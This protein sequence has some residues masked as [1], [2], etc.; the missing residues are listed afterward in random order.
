MPTWSQIAEPYGEYFSETFNISNQLDRYI[1]TIVITKINIHDQTMDFYYSVSGDSMEW[2]EWKPFNEGSTEIFDNYDLSNLYFKYKVI[3][4]SESSTKKPYLQSI[5]FL[6][7]PFSNNINIGDLPS[8]PKIWIRKVNG[9][10]DIRLTNH[11]T[12]QTLILTEM[13]NEEEVFIDCDNEE[14]IS[15]LQ[16]LGVY[17][18]DSHNDEFLELIRGDNY[19]KGQGDFDIDIRIQSP[20][21]QE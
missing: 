13:Q 18:Y 9:D 7:Q 16:Y 20:L 12:N 14:I 19:L 11:M 5:S 3:M 2:T 1:S 4:K 8:Y 10:G 17:R 21:L 6:L 15:S